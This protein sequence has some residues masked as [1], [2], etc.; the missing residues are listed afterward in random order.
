MKVMASVLAALLVPQAGPTFRTNVER[1]QVDVSVTRDGQPVPGLSASDFV[2][3]DNGD[4]QD[5]ESV[6]LEDVPLSVQLL[7]D[8]SASVSG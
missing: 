8:T 2:L 1:V 6:V 4:P 3:T 5:L 7:L